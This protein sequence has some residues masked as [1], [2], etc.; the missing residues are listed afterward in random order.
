[1]RKDLISAV[2]PETCNFTSSLLV[3]SELLPRSDERNLS[4]NFSPV[5]TSIRTSGGN[6]RG[7]RII[8]ATPTDVVLIPCLLFFSWDIFTH[9]GSS[10]YAT[11]HDARCII[12]HW[13]CFV[14]M[15]FWGRHPCISISSTE[16]Q[17][18]QIS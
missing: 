12:C 13:Q 1:M 3:E 8:N 15:K 5:L 14:P 11:R 7:E 10:H 2:A 17:W 16:K 4:E 18:T 9:R 6:R